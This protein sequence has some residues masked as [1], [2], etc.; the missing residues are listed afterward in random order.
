MKISDIGERELVTSMFKTG[1]I[2]GGD[3][4]CIEISIGGKRLLASTDSVSSD[5]NIPIGAT[6]AQIGK[7]LADI[8]LSDIAAMAGNPI[9]MLSSFN[10]PGKIDS[11]FV[12]GLVEAI[13][14]ELNVFGAEYLGG[15]TKESRSMVLSGMI[16]GEQQEKLI[17]HRSDIRQ[18]QVLCVTGDLGRAAAGYTFYKTGYRKKL[19]IN[20]LMD[21]VP[22][23]REAKII[24][25]NGGKFMT[26]LSDGVLESIYKAKRDF[27]IGFRLVQDEIPVNEQVKKAIQLS[28]AAE[29]DLTLSFG[30][31]YEILFTIDNDNYADFKTA[32]D[33]EKIHVSYIGDTWKG[34]N[35]IFDGRSWKPIEGGGYQHFA[36]VPKIGSIS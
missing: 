10:L 29:N 23:I 26:D 19:G 24:S 5:T 8:N 18:G 14:K 3:N 31:D 9:G 32:M 34:E 27:G 4:D 35:M 20:L 36:P 7:F 21:F 12:L 16:I 13:D 30:G 33:S 15:D 22:R 2:H 6:S 25:E 11:N 17:R 1:H 28:G